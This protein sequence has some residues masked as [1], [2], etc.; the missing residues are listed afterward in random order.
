M[1]LFVLSSLFC[2]VAL[3]A[4]AA[5]STGYKVTSRFHVPGDGGWDYITYDGSANRLYVSHGTEVY[6]L[7]A[8]D[9]KILGK[10][11][12]TPG[13]HGIAIVPKLHRGFTTNGREAKVSMFDT[14]TFKTIK[15]IP[16]AN[17]PDFIFYD[18]AS[19]RVF[20]DNGDAQQTTAIDPVKGEVIGKVALGGSPEAAVSDGKGTVYVNLEDKAEIVRFDAKTLE[21]KPGAWPISD[22]KGPTGIAMDTKNERLFTGCHSKIMGVLDAKTGKSLATLPIG[23][24]VD[25]AAFDAADKLAFASTRDGGVTVVHEDSP[26]KFEVVETIHTQEGARTMALDAKSKKLFLPTAEFEP[27][28][29]GERRPKLKP[30]TFVVLVVSK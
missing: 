24:G 3:S 26:N 25:A 21:L 28:Q 7:D 8:N 12:D 2:A 5:D 29:A 22:C 30:G 4:L 11:E 13:V 23:T 16:T 9:G 20:V 18:P 14:R 17:D 19:G 1:R 6:V 10:I 27:L 15:K